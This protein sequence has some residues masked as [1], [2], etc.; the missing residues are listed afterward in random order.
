MKKKKEKED[1]GM[2]RYYQRAREANLRANLKKMN[3]ESQDKFQK[4]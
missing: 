2:R 1:K 4:I 3:S